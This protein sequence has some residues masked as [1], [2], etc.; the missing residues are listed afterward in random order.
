MNVLDFKEHTRSRWVGINQ[1]EYLNFAV[2]PTLK[3][4]SL[5]PP[6]FVA[7]IDESSVCVVTVA[8]SLCSYIQTLIPPTL[9]PVPALCLK[10]KTTTTP[11]FSL[12]VLIMKIDHVSNHTILLHCSSFLS[13]RVGRLSLV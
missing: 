7:A 2:S 9:P 12:I 6:F 5:S 1:Y 3:T 8:A 13:C 10:Q 4:L 11:N